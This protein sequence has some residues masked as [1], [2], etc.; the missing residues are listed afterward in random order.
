MGLISKITDVVSGSAFKTITDTVKD[1]FPP[2]MSE[3]E[4]AEL[5]LKIYK[6][7][8]ERN[9]VILTAANEADQLFNQRIKDTEGTAADLKTI[10]F[11]GHII[12]FLRGCQRPIFGFFTLIMDYQVFTKN[13]TF[14]KE[15]QQA[16]AFIVL[17]IVV[18]IFLFGERT[19]KNVLPIIMSYF[20][21]KK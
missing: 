6:S 19:V 10:P 5:E 18:L 14:E 15:S 1:Y 3:A 20:G 17:N 11:L 12:I 8:T 4:K 2:S 21:A 13:W 7:E 9:T 16:A